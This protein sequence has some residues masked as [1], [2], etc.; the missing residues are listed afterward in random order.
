MTTCGLYELSSRYSVEIGIPAKSSVSGI[1]LGV[2]PGAGVIACYSP[3]LER[4]GNSV[5]GL[6]L[7][8][9]ISINSYLSVFW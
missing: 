5:A 4:Q 8:K 3:P 2:V 7:L 1:V 9:L 6:F